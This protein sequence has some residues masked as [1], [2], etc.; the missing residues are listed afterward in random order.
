MRT[1]RLAL[2]A[3]LALAGLAPVQAQDIPIQKDIVYGKA[4][5]EELKLDLARPAK[6]EG[7]FPLVVCLHGGAWQIGH[8][9]AQH[10]RLSLLAEHGYVAA[11]VGYRLA[12]KHP[13]P[14][15][16]EDAKSAVRFLRAHAKEYL[17]DPKRVA[18]AGD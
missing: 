3:W 4:G 1:R 6:G 11:A 10:P 12:P 5:G 15:Q 8:R 9:S 16:I 14:A 2:V 13:Y 17:T 18:A 7:P